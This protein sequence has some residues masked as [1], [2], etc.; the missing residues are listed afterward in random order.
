MR[1]ERE[2][3]PIYGS[4]IKSKLNLTALFAYFKLS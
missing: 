4:R 3:E 1:R 2:R